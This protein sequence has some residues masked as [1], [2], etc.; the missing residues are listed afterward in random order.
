M[1]SAVCLQK[2]LLFLVAMPSSHIL[3]GA[4]TDHND[5][6]SNAPFAIMPSDRWTL[7]SD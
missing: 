6:S 1:K 7:R 4:R 2:K 5:H 3:K